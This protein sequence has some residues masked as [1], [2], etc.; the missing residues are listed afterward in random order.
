MPDRPLA[1][2]PVTSE[3]RPP[4]AGTLLYASEGY[5]THDRRFI[6]AATEQ[7]WRVHVARF[8]G[9]QRQLDRRPLPTGAA[10]V[11][12]RGSREPLTE[13]EPTPFIEAFGELVADLRPD[14]VHAGPVPTVA[15]VAGAAGGAPLVAMSW[16]SDLLIDIERSPLA[17]TRAAAA[18]AGAAEVLVDCRTVAD[19]AVALGAARNHVTVVPWGVDLSSLPYADA[20]PEPDGPTLRL[21]S[22]RSFEPIYDLPTLLTAVSRARRSLGPGRL[23]LSLA[24]SGSE[25]DALRALA[26][27]LDLTDDLTWLGR[28]GEDEVPALLAAHDVHVST[29]RSD[30]S[31]ISLLQA[32]AVGRPS[33]VTD[34]PSNRE[35]VSPGRTGWVFAPGDADALA[36]VL[37]DL[38]GRRH[39]LNGV[40]LAGRQLVEQQADWQVNR[41]RVAETYRRAMAP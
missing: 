7:G 29:S 26:D 24:G 13:D 35:W 10:P 18:L 16:A 39:D 28:V 14:V 3:V 40:A 20:A 27:R 9:G 2:P 25:H 36:A 34:L 23:A 21:V 1:D 32:M 5:T 4:D 15:F 31:S 12:W 19:I 22:L 37:V 11:E 17:R 8:D 41:R 38:H 6:A 33:V 30:G